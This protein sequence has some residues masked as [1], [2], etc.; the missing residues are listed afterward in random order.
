MK[1]VGQNTVERAF[2]LAA[3]GRF[4]TIQHLVIALR[5]ENYVDAA[6]QLDGRTL[7]RQLVALMATS[8]SGCLTP[9]AIEEDDCP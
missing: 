9:G 1:T 7:R 6:A 2:Q 3:S 5:A 4:G 8:Q